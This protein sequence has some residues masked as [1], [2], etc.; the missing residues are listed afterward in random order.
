VRELCDVA[1]VVDSDDY[2]VIEDA[3]VALNHIVTSYFGKW[4]QGRQRS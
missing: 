3:H 4:V 2:G 1:V